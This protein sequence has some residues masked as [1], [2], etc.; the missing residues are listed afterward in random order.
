METP[1][2]TQHWCRGAE[3]SFHAMQGQKSQSLISVAHSLLDV[4]GPFHKQAAPVPVPSI[5]MTDCL[6]N[7]GMSETT[8]KR[9]STSTS[10]KE[11]TLQRSE[12]TAL[13]TYPVHIIIIFHDQESEPT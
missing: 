4:L 7:E 9:T 12:N 10:W 2:G 6:S 8:K 3:A 5:Q 1:S 13:E 11:L